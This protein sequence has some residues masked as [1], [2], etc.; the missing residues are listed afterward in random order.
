VFK[1]AGL[2]VPADTPFISTGSQGVH[3][4]HLGFILAEMQ[5]LQR[6]FPGG[7]W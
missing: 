7:A 3:S 2:A 4:E 5:A 1:E 6:T